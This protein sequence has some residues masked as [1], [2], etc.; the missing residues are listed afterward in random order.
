MLWGKR[1]VFRR[2][3]CYDYELHGYSY[4][5]SSRLDLLD[6]YIAHLLCCVHRQKLYF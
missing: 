4:Y 1:P 3:K 2:K 6:M 5:N